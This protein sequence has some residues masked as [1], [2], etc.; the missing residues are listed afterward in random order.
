MT[1]SLNKV[2]GVTFMLIRLGSVLRQFAP[3]CDVHVDVNVNQLIKH[4][5]PVSI[6]V[7]YHLGSNPHGVI[8][9]NVKDL[10]PST[11]LNMPR[12]F[13]AARIPRRDQS[14][15]T[16]TKTSAADTRLIG[17]HHRVYRNEHRRSGFP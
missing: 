12:C 14:C 11:I 9:S 10:H 7:S 1:Y 4:Y 13:H 15:R 17:R 2:R 16:P 5:D 6:S 8:P 3:R